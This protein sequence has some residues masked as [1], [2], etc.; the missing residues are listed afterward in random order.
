MMI[1]DASGK[2][3]RVA[4][5]YAA[6]SFD[7]GEMWPTRRLISDDGPPR[8]M[9]TADRRTF[10]E[11]KQR[12]D[13][14]ILGHHAGAERRHSSDQQQKPLCAQSGVVED[15]CPDVALKIRPKQQLSLFSRAAR[16]ASCLHR[17]SGSNA[18]PIYAQ[19]FPVRRSDFLAMYPTC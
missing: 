7:E 16:P 8:E 2:Q 19:L 5:L 3:R 10:T 11:R 14:R 15:A 18:R 1:T 6:L 4:V 9:E 17:T 12:R 13:V